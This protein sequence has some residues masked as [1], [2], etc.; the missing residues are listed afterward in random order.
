MLMDCF[1]LD[2]VE[3]WEDFMSMA[4]LL[5]ALTLISILSPIVARTH[6]GRLL[7]SKKKC[8]LEFHKYGIL[9][10]LRL[11]GAFSLSFWHV[12]Q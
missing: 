4:M 2:C 7:F 10:L 6:I 11:D 5:A 8:L 1:G 9:N 12:N 3:F